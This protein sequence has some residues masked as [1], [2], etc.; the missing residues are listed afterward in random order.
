MTRFL[1]GLTA[2]LIG[3]TAAADGFSSLFVTATQS[4][5]D[6]SVLSNMRFT[7][8]MLAK[9][10]SGA[11]STG[12]SVTRE[13]A[14]AS[15]AGVGAPSSTATGYVVDRAVSRRVRDE[16][17]QRLAKSNP[18]AAEA[19][20]AQMRQHDFGRVYASLVAPF[21]LRRGDVADAMTAYTVLGWMVA[22]GGGDPSPQAVRA[23]RAQ[24]AT[25]IGAN[26]QFARSDARS[27]LGEELE[28][29]LVTLHASWRSA[30]QQGIGRQFSDQVAEVFRKQTGNDLRTLVLTDRGM[31]KRS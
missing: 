21:G 31:E 3:S 30:G 12:A 25:Q 23:A 26:P 2:V 5:L 29:L 7:N 10:R 18:A 24:I 6:Y 11:P 13:P 1:I 22:T 20:A 19:L 17:V 15:S 28:I 9:Q 27:A 8:E 4:S 16:F 14:T